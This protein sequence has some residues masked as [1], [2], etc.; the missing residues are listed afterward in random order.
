[1][2]G[3]FVGFIISLP[4]VIAVDSVSNWWM[5]WAA[6]IGFAFELAA[7]LGCGSEFG[8]A[9]CAAIDLSQSLSDV[10]SSIGGGD[11]GYSGGDSGGGGD[12]GGCGGGGD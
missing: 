11:G 4:F 6:L 12:G 9:F 1:M 3:A 7:R 2:I 5:L 8:D 10:G